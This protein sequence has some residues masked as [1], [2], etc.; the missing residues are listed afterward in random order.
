M[1]R[2]GQTSRER[3]FE[4]HL[5]A[6]DDFIL[7]GVKPFDFGVESG[8]HFRV[9]LGGAV[10]KDVVIADLPEIDELAP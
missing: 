2:Q 4:D 5:V 10:A 7:A 6:G 3:Y 8:T 1:L 9:E